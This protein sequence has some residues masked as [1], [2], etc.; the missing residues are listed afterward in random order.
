MARLGDRE[1]ET[2]V[3]DSRNGTIDPKWDIPDDVRK[4]VRFRSRWKRREAARKL[5]ETIQKSGRLLPKDYWPN[6]EFLSNWMGG[7][8]GAYL[9]NFPEFFGDKPVRDVV[10]AERL[11]S[12]RKLDDERRRSGDRQSAHASVQEKRKAR[13][14]RRHGR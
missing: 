10:P 1:K 13:A 8:M 7:T 3:R 12:W 5:E 2:L 11:A 4:S 14:Y 9:R 6:L